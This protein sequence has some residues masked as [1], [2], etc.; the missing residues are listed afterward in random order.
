MRKHLNLSALTG[1]HRPRDWPDPRRSWKASGPFT[2]S[3]RSFVLGAAAAAVGMSPAGRAALA[4]LASSEFTYEDGVAT[5]SLQGSPCWVIDPR[6]FAGSPRLKVERSD[7]GSDEQWLRL[8]LSGARFPGLSL[9]ADFTAEIRPA[10]VGSTMT[11]QMALGGFSTEVSLENWLAGTVPA[12]GVVRLD[13][14]AATL[15]TDSSLR[16][17]GTATATFTPDWQLRLDGTAVAWLSM[18]GELY[19][20]DGVTLAPL[21]DSAP[22]LLNTRIRRR[23][24]VVLEKGAQEWPALPLEDGVINGPCGQLAFSEDCFDLLRLEAAESRAGQVAHACAAES[25]RGSGRARLRPAK[26]QLTQK[27]GSPFELPLTQVRAAVA[28]QPDGDEV[29]V[30]GRFGKAVAVAGACALTLG[31]D[32]DNPG[33]TLQAK[34]GQVTRVQASPAVLKANLPMAGALVQEVRIP[35]RLRLDMAPA[36][37]GRAPAAGGERAV[38]TEN[39]AAMSVRSVTVIR[40]EDMLYLTFDFFGLNL[41]VE[42]G[43]PKLVPDPDAGSAHI[44]VHFQPQHIAEQS[45]NVVLGEPTGRANARIAGPSRVAFMVPNGT[46]LDYSLDDLLDWTNLNKVRLSLRDPDAGS[47]RLSK[48]SDY[49]TAIEA[50]YRL[51]L[52]PVASWTVGEITTESVFTHKLKPVRN[53]ETGRTELWHTRLALRENG[54]IRES[55]LL[56]LQLQAIWARDFDPSAGDP[57]EY[58]PSSDDRKQ[59]VDLTTDTNLSCRAP[60]YAKRLMLSSLGAWLDARGSWDLTGVSGYSLALWEH[61]ML[62]ARDQY[63]KTQNLGFLFPFGHLCS[64]IEVVSREFTQSGVAYLMKRSYIVIHNAVVEYG[65]P[66]FPFRRVEILDDKTP[67]LTDDRDGFGLGERAFWPKVKVGDQVKPFAFRI[68]ATDWNNQ[69]FTFSLYLPFVRKDIAV[70]ADAD[71]ASNI[72][73]VRATYNSHPWRQLNLNGLSV[74]YARPKGEKVSSDSDREEEVSTAF[75]T[76]TIWFMADTPPSSRGSDSPQFRPRLQKAVVHMNQVEGLSNQ[77]APATV[78][79]WETYKQYAFDTDKNSNEIYLELTPPIS[80]SLPEE[81]LNGMVNPDY[82]ICY[83]SRKFGAMGPLNKTSPGTAPPTP[84]QTWGDQKDSKIFGIFDLSAILDIEENDDDFGWLPKLVIEF[85]TLSNELDDEEKDKPPEDIPPGISPSYKW[86]KLPPSTLNEIVGIK[87]GF[88]WE[89]KGLLTSF[90]RNWPIF[91]ASDDEDEPTTIKVSLTKT[92]KFEDDKPSS[93]GGG[94]SSGGGSSGGGG[95][96]SGGGSGDSDD[97]DNGIEFYAGLQ[98]FGVGIPWVATGETLLGVSFEEIAVKREDGKPEVLVAIDG[99]IFGGPLNFFNAFAKWLKALIPSYNPDDNDGEKPEIKKPPM[100][101]LSL[102]LPPLP[103]IWISIFQ[104][105]GIKLGFGLGIPLDKSSS[106]GPEFRFNLSDVE[107]PF[108]FTVL[109]FGGG[110]YFG[111]GF[112]PSRLSYLE[113]GFQ[114]GLILNVQYAVVKGKVTAALGIN[115]RV[116]FPDKDL[117]PNYPT[118]IVQLTGY[119][120]V[121]GQ[122][123]V[124]G[125]VEVSILFLLSLTWIS[126]NNCLSG[127]VQLSI[128]VKIAFFAVKVTLTVRKVFYAEAGK[129]ETALGAGRR[130]QT[131]LSPE[132]KRKYIDAYAKAF[133]V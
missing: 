100:L 116:D 85:I 104:I 110:G 48:P 6:R 4:A 56:E 118:A 120:R 29:A 16:L 8:T 17:V 14:L 105:S 114:V 130:T 78:V 87:V 79:Y 10:L 28:F 43:K 36:P 109:A 88:E 7:P 33:F 68:V 126:L 133:A 1:R 95:G 52:A 80:T 45:F 99:L 9:P 21:A 23:S 53:P 32:Q 27:D 127:T 96:S 89:V 37:L 102:P 2:I 113:A 54:K 115:L 81:G 35:S 64:L 86:P 125:C 75:P 58:T 42:N 70:P 22:S 77:S 61:Q 63:V 92:I 40:P 49:V 51:W 67:F 46:S 71:Q 3:R 31:D 84:V 11:L 97:D 119:V 107:D 103:T 66:G 12:E 121:E 106:S 34:G 50:P 38:L 19:P 20:A 57:F 122:L 91:I 26:G 18:R 47:G 13:D 24:M 74:A 129:S 123:K 60:V 72:K 111:I 82:Q 128:K 83:I 117:N 73:S 132:R 55:D 41:Q 69:S 98:N 65:D 30:T 108:A 25:V 112:T 131:Q 62:M 76:D 101:D 39:G 5:F 93:G 44:V 90:P 94:G 59:L 124:M 15:S